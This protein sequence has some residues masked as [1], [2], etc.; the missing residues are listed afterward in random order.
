MEVTQQFSWGTTNEWMTKDPILYRASLGIEVTDL[1]DEEGNIIYLFKLGDGVRPWQLLPYFNRNNIHGLE[2]FILSHISDMGQSITEL[3]D[4]E[5]V[6]REAADTA[7]DERIAALEA[8]I[9]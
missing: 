1:R 9:G 6:A 7:L 3:I 4:T 8:V 2:D 5:R